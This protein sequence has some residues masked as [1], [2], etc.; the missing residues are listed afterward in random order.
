MSRTDLF[1]KQWRQ[2]EPHLPP[3]PQ[4]GHA[5]VEHRRVLNGPT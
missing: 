2:L 4:R 5:Y 1:E 3:D